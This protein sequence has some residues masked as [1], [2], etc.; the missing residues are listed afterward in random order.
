MI[1]ETEVLFWRLLTVSVIRD[2]DMRKVLHHELVALIHALIH[3]N[4]TMRKDNKAEFSMR[5][6]SHCPRFDICLYH[7]CH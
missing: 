4:E 1:L 5:L 6:E 3:S 7:G 2:V